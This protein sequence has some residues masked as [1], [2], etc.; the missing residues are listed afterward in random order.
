MV[1]PDKQMAACGKRTHDPVR[2]LELSWGV[3][4]PCGSRTER[5]IRGEHTLAVACARLSRAHA[6]D[7]ALCAR[8][9]FVGL[10]LI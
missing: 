9:D 8:Q 3:S 4:N 2:A 10:P 5:E 6:S 1:V 7:R